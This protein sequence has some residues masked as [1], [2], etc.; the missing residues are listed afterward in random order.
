MYVFCRCFCCIIEF[1][2]DCFFSVNIDQSDGSMQ[3]SAYIDEFPF[4][5]YIILRDT[6]AL[7]AVLGDA[8]RQWFEIARQGM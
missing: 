6:N 8:L 4:Q 1:I 5:D 3:M 2:S 7:A